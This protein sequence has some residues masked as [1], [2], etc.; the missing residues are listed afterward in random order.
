MELPQACV[1]L[2]KSDISATEFS[3]Y[4]NRTLVEYGVLY[5]FVSLATTSLIFSTLT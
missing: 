5:V 1:E 3:H 2:E 4:A